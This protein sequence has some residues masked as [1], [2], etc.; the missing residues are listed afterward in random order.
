MENLGLKLEE[1][2][3]P[4]DFVVIDTAHMPTPN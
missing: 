3:G 2:R 4:V 1:R